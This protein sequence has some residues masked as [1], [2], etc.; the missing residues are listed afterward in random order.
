MQTSTSCNTSSLSVYI[1]TTANPWNAEKVN[2]IYRRLHFGASKPEIDAAL[3]LTPETFIDNLVNG[4]LAIQPTAA[5]SWANLSYQDFMNMGLDPDEQ[6][7]NNHNEL[8][9]Q[10]FNELLTLGLRGRLFLFW[11]NHFVTELDQ[12]YCS[13]YLFKY[14]NLLQTHS[15]GNFEDFVRAIGT[16]EAMLIYLNGF[17]NRANSPNEN[18]ARELYELFTLGENNGYTQNDI[19]ETAKA[20]T[21][22]NHISDFCEDIN[23]IPAGQPNS[24]FN[25]SIKT[26]FNQTG[27]WGYD[28]VITLLFQEKGS[29]IAN[30]I[31]KKLYSYFVSPTVND[32]IV[33]EMASSFILDWNIA[34][35]LRTLFKSEHFFDTITLGS[36]IKSPYDLSLNYIKVTNFT[37]SE[38]FKGSLIYL[39][40]VAGQIMFNPVDVA[41]WQGNHDWIN[42]STLTGRWEYMEWMVWQTWNDNPE[43]LRAFAIE[44]SGDSNDPYVVAK[45]IIDRFVPKELHTAADYDIA[46]D[47]FKYTI[48]QNY[49]DDGSWNLYWGEAPFQV[50]LLLIHIL[51]MPE[52]Q[53][54]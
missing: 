23:F 46:T 14:Y 33:S 41:G 16:N 2:H 26:I 36:Q 47:V 28:D 24:T 34:N 38:D 32:T 29:L 6:I 49:Y 45:S 44:A 4:A 51:K 37:I 42:T 48:P 53:I 21:G 17:E 10:T 9:L 13:N 22:Y 27:N 15:M 18:Y 35:V 40:G 54:K 43:E 39:N 52:F 12:Y 8:R 5:P 20:L 50:V 3:T 7:Q 11:S 30:F 1:P 19:V 25:D 31:C